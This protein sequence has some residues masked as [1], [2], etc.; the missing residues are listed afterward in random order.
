MSTIRIFSKKAFSFG[1]GAQPGTDVIENFVTVPGAFQD[2]PDK[3]SSDPTFMLAVKC[4]DVEIIEKKPTVNVANTVDA[5]HKEEQ[6]DDNRSDDGTASVEKFY[7]EL[8]AMNKESTKELAE[9]YGVEFVEGD[10]IKLNK[11]RVMEA[12]KLSIAE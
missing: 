2:M 7:E 8:K 4:R 9:K 3:Y 12:Y 11:K 6:T 1:P 10:S 5:D